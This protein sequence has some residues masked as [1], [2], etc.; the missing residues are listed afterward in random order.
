MQFLPLLSQG[1]RLPYEQSGDSDTVGM[2]WAP[3]IGPPELLCP[4]LLC[5]AGSIRHRR[6]HTFLQGDTQPPRQHCRNLMLQHLPD[7]TG[8]DLEC[9]TRGTFVL[10]FFLYKEWESEDVNFSMAS[11]PFPFPWH[12]LL[13]PSQSGHCLSVPLQIL[14]RFSSSRRK[15]FWMSVYKPRC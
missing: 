11:L 14:A 8:K 13:P 15:P 10:L 5:V 7:V 6:R 3:P 4:T 9:V 12:L 1:F 2:A